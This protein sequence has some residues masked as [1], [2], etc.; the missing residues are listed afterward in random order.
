MPMVMADTLSLGKENGKV[1]EKIILHTFHKY[2]C[3]SRKENGK[4][5]EKIEK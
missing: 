3:R 1:T 2:N 5:T 4:V